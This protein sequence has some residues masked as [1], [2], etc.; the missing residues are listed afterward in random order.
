MSASVDGPVAALD[1]G[2]NSTRV[3]V[4]DRNGRALERLMRIT[5]LGEGVD[6][7]RKLDPAAI[8]RTTAVLGEFREV[9]DRHGVT[10]TRL[11]ATS[12]VR[13]AAN[14]DEFLAAARNATGVE[15]EL[16]SGDEEGRLAYLGATAELPEDSG[17][18][19]DTVVIDIGGGSTE[20]VVG[21]RGSV[22]AV[23]LDLGCVRLTERHLLHDPPT[24][25]ELFEARSTVAAALDDA[26]RAVPSL[27][28]LRPARRLLG[29]AGTVTTIS[30]LE[31]RLAVYDRARIHHS[32]L[33]VGTV[34]TWCAT[35][36]GETAS[37]RR[38]RPGM[39]PGRE[40]VIVGGVLVLSEFMARFRFDRCLVSEA[41]ILD[42]L[43]ETLRAA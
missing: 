9:M 30:A 13:D 18:G 37:A 19:Q 5:R 25:A 17:E 11:V 28:S 26:V 42:G 3:L 32:D 33:P 27:A 2:T 38:S 10:A 16:L 1:C 7:T 21:R 20:V 29:L 34:D 23:S 6:A 12:A 31:Q 8:D 39:T 24:A 4:A 22:S 43:V 41:D 35:L 15:P 36:A 40:D 14:G